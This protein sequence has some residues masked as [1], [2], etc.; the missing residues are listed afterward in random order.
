[1]LLSP[2]PSLGSG[3][4]S[5]EKPQETLYSASMVRIRTLKG[6]CVEDLVPSLALVGSGGTFKRWSL[7]GGLLVIETVPLKKMVR[8]PTSSSSFCFPALSGEQLCS[9][10]VLS[11]CFAASPQAQKQL[12]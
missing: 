6:L 11:P 8:P 10:H 12:G 4:D 7:V 3:S 2:R 5:Q 1:M 9:M